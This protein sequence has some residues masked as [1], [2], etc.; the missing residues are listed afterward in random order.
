[1]TKISP[2]RPSPFRAFGAATVLIVCTG[3]AISCSNGEEPPQASA[4]IADD[5][6]AAVLAQADD[7]ALVSEALQETGL[8]EVFD[9]TASY[10]ILAPTDPAFAD[11]ASMDPSPAERGAIVAAI[12][13]EHVLPGTL[14]I[15]DIAAAIAREDGPVE[16][17]TMGA[18]TLTFADASQENIITVTASDGSSA[19]LTGAALSASN[20]VVIAID[21]LLKSPGTG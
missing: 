8:A 10:T 7:L 20:G 9:G 2:R 1:M 17:Q 14:T 19:R 6:L 3:C 18:G 21:A 16:M 5:T 11:I 4:E 12:L 13:R 15:E